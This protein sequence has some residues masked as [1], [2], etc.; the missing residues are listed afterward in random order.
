MDA[1]ARRPGPRPPA[2]PVTLPL[3]AELRGRFVRRYKRFFADVKLESGRT[4]TVHCPNPGSMLGFHR[5]GAL[6]RC[7]SSSDPRRKLRHTLEMMRVGRVFV[8]LHTG[9]A[10]PLVE[11]AL[12]AGALPELADYAFVRREVRAGASRLD[13]RLG[14]HPRDPR[15]AWVEVKSVTLAER[16]VALFPDSVTTRGRRH[17]EELAVLSRGGDRAVLLY[18]V[19]RADCRRVAPADDIDPDYGAALRAAAR[20][21]V[22]VLAVAAR[23][24]ARGIRLERALP[25]TL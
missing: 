18:V 5:P 15:N 1:H 6:V 20:A 23:V 22:E 4:L 9:R 16:G 21:G 7:S 14:G 13:F 12:R 11:R 25:V 24:S 3:R 10:N 8:G 2:R 17:L 19:Q